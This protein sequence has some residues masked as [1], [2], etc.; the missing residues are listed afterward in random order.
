MS[1][2]AVVHSGYLWKKGGFRKNWNSRFFV[3]SSDGTLKYFESHLPKK[4][5]KPC[6]VI[7]LDGAAVMQLPSSHAS[8]KD[9]FPFTIAPESGS[10]RYYIEATSKSDHDKWTNVILHHGAY[11]KP[12]NLK[13]WHR[14]S[15]IDLPESDPANWSGF[16]FK[17]GGSVKNWKHRFFSL[18]EKVMTYFETENK[19]KKKGSFVV[20]GSKV[21]ILTE[22]ER[23]KVVGGRHGCIFSI[24]PKLEKRVYM[25]QADTEEQRKVWL[26]KLA[27]NDATV[28]SASER[29]NSVSKGKNDAN[30]TSD[31]ATRC[32]QCNVNF[33]LM[34]RK[35]TCSL[36]CQAVCKSCSINRDAPRPAA[37]TASSSALAMTSEKEK[38]LWCSKC[39]ELLYNGQTTDD[40]LDDGKQTKEHETNSNVSLNPVSRVELSELEVQP[41][42][43]PTADCT[44][45][46]Q[47]EKTSKRVS[48]KAFLSPSAHNQK[49]SVQI[50]SP[51]ITVNLSELE[52]QTSVSDTTKHHGNITTSANNYSLHQLQDLEEIEEPFTVESGISPIR[53][54]GFSAVTAAGD[55]YTSENWFVVDEE[56]VQA[57][58][59][60]SFLNSQNDFSHNQSLTL[61]TKLPPSL[62]SLP[63][64]LPNLSLSSISQ[65]SSCLPPPPLPP[66]P[67]HF[68]TTLDSGSGAVDNID[69]TKI[70]RVVRKNRNSGSSH[71]HS[72]NNKENVAHQHKPVRHINLVSKK[73]S[74]Q[75]S[76]DFGEVL[77]SNKRDHKS[78]RFAQSWE[79]TF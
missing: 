13:D 34:R 69:E 8:S 40:V 33:G 26:Q 16:L 70:V 62:P 14:E 46:Q 78:P 6:G 71:P 61:S 22:K 4:M 73:R 28:D 29:S 60:I 42:N 25:L 20:E 68:S 79:S 49:R 31:T 18:E 56:D 45:Q 50:K 11:L 10:R 77:D 32:C 19:I 21:C 17:Q 54:R 51:S 48:P 57:L 53:K 24:T 52:Y 12:Y 30:K 39:Y 66:L 43:R 38:A 7:N 47:I 76:L 72:T 9:R 15:M 75:E 3:L 1:E 64:P 65:P 63:P 59:A 37:E 36:C 27:L 55:S 23:T 2:Q 67:T 44:S 74:K 35:N 5:K 41:S 58:D